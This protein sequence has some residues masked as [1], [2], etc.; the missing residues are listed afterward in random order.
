MPTTLF[1]SYPKRS[2]GP[3]S[4]DGQASLLV[5]HFQSSKYSSILQAMTHGSLRLDKKSGIAGKLSTAK[6][7]NP[8]FNLEIAS[9]IVSWKYFTKKNSCDHH[10]QLCEINALNH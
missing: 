8:N 2:F 9:I 6:A 7:L 1:R 3:S 4:Q 5:P 10:T